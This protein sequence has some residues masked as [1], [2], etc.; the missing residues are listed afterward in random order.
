MSAASPG[1]G[2]FAEG[3]RSL[4]ERRSLT[5]EELAARAGLTGKAVGALERGER[6]RPYPH[7]I[8]ALADALDLDDDERA[9]LAAAARPPS[10]P[11]GEGVHR[12]PA[13]TTP[14]LGRDAEREEIVALLR[15][16]TTRLLTLT[17]PGGVGKTS[18]A[19]DV[20]RTLA[21]DFP[22]GV[23]V[24]ALAPV[25]EP[26]LV[27]PTVARAVGAQ[28]L[29]APLVDALA[30]YLGNRRQ[31]VVLDNVEHVLACAGDVAELIARCPR[32]VVL[33]T[34]RAALRV[35]AERERPL[36]PLAV[37]AG[38]GAAAVA[39][40]P[41]AQVFLDRAA[42]VGRPLPLDD[43]TAA[44]VA[45]I[46][47]RLD[48]LPLALELAAAHARYLSPAALLDRL[49]ASLASPS[50]RDLP[51]R[52]RTMRATLDWSHDLLTA[53]E[54]RLLRRLSVFAGGFSLEAAQQV[55]DDDVLPVLAGLVEQSLVLPEP[56]AAPR[57]RVLEPIRQY[58]AARL[59]QAGEADAVADRA[60]DFFAGLAARARTGLRTA[61]Q[62]GWLDALS[63]DHD[64]LGAALRRLLDRGDPRTAATLL[65]DTWLYWALRGH[66]VEGL[67]WVRVVAAAGGT[68]AAL[69]LAGAALGLAAGDLPGTARAAEA[70]VA[71]A[72]AAGDQD[73][74]AEALL[75]AGMAAV[76]TGAFDTARNRLAEV[77]ALPRSPGRRWVDAHSAMTHGQLAFVAGDLAGGTAALAEAERLARELASPFS[78]ATALNVQASVA[79]A[80]D[81]DATALDCWAEAGALAAEV[82]T[83]W[84]LAYTLPGLAI[85]AARRGLPELAA[86]L[87][88]AG[89]ATAEADSVAVT[90]P[91]DLAVAAQWLHTVRAELGER[92]FTA[93]WER[94]RGLRPS[95]VPRV[96]E[97]IS[98]RSAPG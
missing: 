56:D 14:L 16:G 98:D 15:S 17:G 13:R 72:R 24:A 57:Y 54:Q 26:A 6:R 82:G 63:R 95:D 31:L 80:A 42:A 64:N 21:P 4:R 46:C 19:L 87:F 3:L 44:A 32:L 67:G 65:A 20:A 85:V 35:R 38:P 29:P 33:A 10:T 45:A 59:Q 76:F 93:A 68:G 36:T 5:Q 43:A 81:D 94:G 83:S 70:A 2:A 88:A 41:A 30:A 8:R 50:A 84:T 28:A 62:A 66:T 91:P 61:E 39:A 89:S 86:E 7:T 74:L 52:Q 69:H 55:A 77:D 27:L 40:S 11:D 25:G 58:A 47:R 75:F 18:L 48:G 78:L 73:V 96:A 37:P 92:D 79:L 71:G 51:P 12:L 49:D 97:L 23:A 53:A 1:P 22:D 60:A 34:S 90:F 9:A